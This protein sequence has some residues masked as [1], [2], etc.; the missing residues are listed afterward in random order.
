MVATLTWMAGSVA[1]VSTFSSIVTGFIMEFNVAW[2]QS[3]IFLVVIPS[4]L[5]T[6]GKLAIKYEWVQHKNNYIL[7]RRTGMV[8]IPGKRGQTLTLPFDEFD[9]YLI[10]VTNPTGSSDFA[11]HLGHRYSTACFQ[12]HGAHSDYWYVYQSWEFWQQYMDI[13]QPL[14]DVPYMEPFRS[15]D[16]VTAEFDRRT[17][18]PPDA[19]KNLERDTFFAMDKASVKAVKKFPWGSTR[20]Q[21]LAA[22][23][24][25]SGCGEGPSSRFSLPR[26]N[27]EKPEEAR[28]SDRSRSAR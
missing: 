16:P 19:W 22:G 5:Y 14:P 13:S 18:R 20:A 2:V 26:V 6:L 10:T 4:L 11:F 8:T 3:V 7:N 12:L 1:L 23:W 24:K 15:R 9:P 25:P 28:S 21:A 17:K 27:A